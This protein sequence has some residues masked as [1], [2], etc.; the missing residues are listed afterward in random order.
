MSKDFKIKILVNSYIIKKMKKNEKNSL[1]NTSSNSNNKTKKFYT[2]FVTPNQNKKTISPF[3]S[4]YNKNIYLNK[5]KNTETINFDRNHND[6]SLNNNSNDLKTRTINKNNIEI[7]P[8]HENKFKNINKNIMDNIINKNKS[9]KQKNKFS[10]YTNYNNNI[11]NSNDLQKYYSCNKTKSNTLKYNNNDNNIKIN[12]VVNN[13][14]VI[15]EN[16]SVYKNNNKNG[17]SPNKN[18]KKNDNYLQ[19]QNKLKKYYED[20]SKKDRITLKTE[21]KELIDNKNYYS[22]NIIKKKLNLNTI[23]TNVKSNKDINDLNN[24]KINKI[25][26]Y[27]SKSRDNGN[28]IIRNLKEKFINNKNILP[29]LDVRS[30]LNH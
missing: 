10:N 13:I 4:D 5:Y 26:N 11:N 6:F 3:L 21:I 24:N 12:S 2:Q 23:D 30:K 27:R 18:Y 1:E 29:P 16:D 19:I 22:R 17:N 7:S 28:N 25:I 9:A 14:N 8:I 20:I 15:W